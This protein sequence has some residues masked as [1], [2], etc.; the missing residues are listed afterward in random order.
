MCLG[1]VS[2][3]LFRCRNKYEYECECE[4]SEIV[5]HKSMLKEPREYEY[6]CPHYVQTLNENADRNLL[7]RT[8]DLTTSP[9]RQYLL[10][11]LQM[12]SGT[13]RPICPTPP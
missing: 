1:P 3:F 7:T 9:S 6:K 12:P 13:C 5:I 10:R 8:Q 11:T 2:L 4:L